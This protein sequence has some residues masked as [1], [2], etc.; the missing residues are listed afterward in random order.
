MQEDSKFSF[1]E[2]SFSRYVV[3]LKDEDLAELTK[4]GGSSTSSGKWSMLYDQGLIVDTDN[5]RYYTN[6]KYTLLSSIS[7]PAEIKRVEVSDYEKFNSQC[8]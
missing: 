3:K 2:G 4:D 6:F 7:E 8:D 5:T 1:P